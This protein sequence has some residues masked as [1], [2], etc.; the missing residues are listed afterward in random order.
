MF[1]KKH[2]EEPETRL[3]RKCYLPFGLCRA[4]NIPSTIKGKPLEMISDCA[5]LRFVLVLFS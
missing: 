2:P 1:V 5:E 4:D 3:V